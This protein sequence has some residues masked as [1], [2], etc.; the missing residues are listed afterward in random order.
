MGW[1]KQTAMTSDSIEDRPIV[2]PEQETLAMG[3]E[4]IPTNPETLGLLKGM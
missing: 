2:D 1:E 3:N 4:S